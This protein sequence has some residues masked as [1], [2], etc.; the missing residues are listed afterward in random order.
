MYYNFAIKW[1]TKTLTRQ[2]INVFAALLLGASSI[3]TRGPALKCP[4]PPN[5]ILNHKANVAWLVAAVLQ[6][7]ATVAFSRTETCNKRK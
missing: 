4:L 7:C 5:R 6:I 3:V 1:L 2:P